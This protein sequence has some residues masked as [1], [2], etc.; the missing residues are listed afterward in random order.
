V[1]Q[2]LFSSPEVVPCDKGQPADDPLKYWNSRIRSQ[3]DPAHFALD[4][5]AIPA[6]SPECERIF[7]SAKLLI[8]ASQNRL[9][10]N[11]I[12][13][14]EC[15]RAWFGVMELYSGIK[16]LCISYERESC[17]KDSPKFEKEIEVVCD[18][19]EVNPAPGTTP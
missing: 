11:I 6:S 5:L 9:H 13:A 15:L 14:N 12:E 19:P 7:S 4:M 3:P 8:T 16:N 2:L 18:L 1:I 17:Y 10:P